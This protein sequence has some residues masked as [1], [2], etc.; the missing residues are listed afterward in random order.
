M[1]IE[2]KEYDVQESDFD[3]ECCVAEISEEAMEYD[4]IMALPLMERVAMEGHFV[5]DTEKIEFL[6]QV[7]LKADKLMQDVGPQLLPMLEGIAKNPMLK[8]FMK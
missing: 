6:Y 3:V 8:M 5:R 4:R 2:P 1:T 7:A